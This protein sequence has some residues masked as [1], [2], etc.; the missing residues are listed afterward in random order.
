MIDSVLN[1][2]RVNNEDSRMVALAIAV[3]PDADDLPGCRNENDL[4]PKVK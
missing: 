1:A 4:G 2:F 3:A